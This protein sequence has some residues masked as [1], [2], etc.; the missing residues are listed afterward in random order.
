MLWPYVCRQPTDSNAC[1]LLCTAMAEQ[2]AMLRA[3]LACN[4]QQESCDSG[5]TV[6]VT[7]VVIIMM[8]TPVIM[9]MMVMT[10]MVAP[11]P[12]QEVAPAARRSSCSSCSRGG[13]ACTGERDVTWLIE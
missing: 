4:K 6:M 13:V 11:A 8:V 9:T 3:I 2:M 10:V 12:V 5:P 1:G 7:A